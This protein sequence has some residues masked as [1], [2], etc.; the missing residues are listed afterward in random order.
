M[1]PFALWIFI[2]W[3]LSTLSQDLPV[4]RSNANIRNRFPVATETEIDVFLPIKSGPNDGFL[5]RKASAPNSGVFS[6]SNDGK[7]E[8]IYPLSAI[9][10]MQFATIVDFTCDGSNVFILLKHFNE[11][12]EPKYLL[13]KFDTTQTFDSLEQV[14]IEWEPKQI[15]AFSSSDFLFTGSTH[16]GIPV[17]AIVNSRGQ[18]ERNLTIP[19]HTSKVPAI[20]S[21]DRQQCDLMSLESRVAETA[22]N[23]RVYLWGF[24]SN[25][26]Y[27]VNRDGSVKRMEIPAPKSGRLTSL[28]VHKYT[29]IALYRFHVNSDRALTMGYMVNT[30]TGK[31]VSEITIPMLNGSVLAGFTGTDLTFL[32]VEI[33][34]SKPHLALIDTTIGP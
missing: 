17:L 31:L 18:V 19:D 20:R 11:R 13:A 23:Q 26:I 5:Y 27:I 28:K 32:G 3:C 22:N 4:L 6:I 21:D 9:P 2:L 12:K 34:D 24:G 33:M 7:E 25:D 16:E 8:R 10:S 1:K 29:A 30:Q 14:S 15:A